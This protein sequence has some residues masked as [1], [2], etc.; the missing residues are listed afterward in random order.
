[1]NKSFKE[2]KERV[3]GRIDLSR[4]GSVDVAI[5]PL[6]E[7]LNGRECYYTTSS[8]SG[9]LV[10]FAEVPPYPPPPPLVLSMMMM[11]MM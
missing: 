5:S 7:F 10:I 6:L 11:M 4:K 8:C 9:R 1:M 3:L 2:D